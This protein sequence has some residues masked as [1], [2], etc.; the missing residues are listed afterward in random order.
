MRAHLFSWKRDSGWTGAGDFAIAP[1]LVFYF[2]G[3]IA[4]EPAERFAELRALFP[5]AYLF[6]CSTGGQIRGDEV[7][8]DEIAAVALSFDKTRL[9]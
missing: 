8:D 3:R 9:R 2:G 4:L 1:Q 6:G 7:F 5:G